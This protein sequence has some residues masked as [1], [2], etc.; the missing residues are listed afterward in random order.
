MIQPPDGNGPVN[1]AERRVVH[2]LVATLPENYIVIPNIEISEP[3]RQRFEYD[4][5]VVSPHAV[6]VLEVKDW[7]GKIVG[8]NVGWLVNGRSR[9]APIGATERKAKVLKSK[10]VA[11][12]PALVRVRVEAAVVL[13]SEPSSIDLTPEAAERTFSLD[14][15]LAFMM[16]PEA[17][18]QNPNCIA[19]LRLVI[20]EAIAGVGKRRQPVLRFG[21]YEVVETL[22]QDEDEAVYRARHKDM[23][24]APEVRLRVVT[25]S[26][27]LLT[28][29]QRAARKQQLF[30]EMEALLRMG[31]HPNVIAARTVF[32][33]DSGRVVVVLDSTEGR[34]LRQRLNNGTPL[35]V[36]QRIGIL[37]GV[38]RALAHAHSHGVIHRRVT[39]E[40]ILIDELGTVRL[41]QFGFSKLLVPQA[42]TVWDADA[43]SS[44][45]RRYLAPELN[46][47]ALGAPN[48]GTDLYGLGCIAF[49]LFAGTPPFEGPEQAFIGPPSVPVEMPQLL[50]EVLPSLLRAD[51]TVRA[52]DTKGALATLESLQGSGRSRPATG[53]KNDYEPGDLIDGKFEVR[54]RLGEGGFS[55]VYRVYL[56]MEDRE[57]ALKIFNA[58]D[59]YDKVQR[60]I[61][62]LRSINHEHIVKVV[63][64]D[65]TQAKQWYIVT[66][67]V[68]GQ[69]LSEYTE[70]AKRLAPQEALTIILDLLGALEAIQ[71]DEQRIAELRAKSELSADEFEELQHL[72]SGGIVHRDIKPQ[73]LI[74]SEDPEQG[75]VLIDFNIASKVGDPVVTVSGTPRY[76]APDANYT[77]WTVST[78]LFATAVVLYELLCAEHPYEDGQPRVDRVPIDARQF[79][80][81]FSPELCAFLTRACSPLAEQ[82]FS[83]A[84]E[85]RAALAAI[86]SL[87]VITRKATRG[88]LTPE[89]ARL[90][91]NVPRNV[92]PFVRE[93]L[94]LGSQARISNRSTRGLTDIARATYVPTRLDDELAISLLSGHHTLVV[95]TGN[96]GDGKTAFIQQVE[97]LAKEKGAIVEHST[98][99]G[100]HL[101]FANHRI[102]TLYDGS[103]DEEQRT[104]DDV[105]KEFFAPFAV[106]ANIDHGTVRIGAINEGRL[107]DF[108][109]AFRQDFPV[110]LDLLTQLDS[111]GSSEQDERIVLVNLNLRSLTGGGDQSIFTRQLRSIVD[112][113]FWEP[114]QACDYRTRCPIKHN[115]DTFR[116]PTS[117]ALV[118]ER[119]RRLIDLVRLRRRRHLTMR[120]LRSIISFILFRDRTC[121]EI[122]EVLRV[123]EPMEIADLAYFQGIGGLGVASGSVRDRVA[124]LLAE[125]DVAL[126]ANPNEDRSLAQ[127]R[128]PRRMNF[129]SRE[130]DYP[131]ELLMEA[132]RRAGYGYEGNPPTARRV[133]EALRR[134]V[135]FERSDDRWWDMLPYRKLKEFEK[136]LDAS[137]AGTR[138]QLRDEI[139]SALSSAEGIG[140]PKRGEALWIATNDE[141]E[142]GV[143]SYRRFAAADFMLGIVELSATY[144]EWQP[145]QL[146]LLH[147]PSGVALPIGVEL[148]GDPRAIARR[149]CALA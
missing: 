88:V 27:Y 132:Q 133:H 121:E 49:E 52:Q 93:F 26:R 84:R 85:M 34:T 59:A 86:D 31:S 91:E 42:A 102:V 137:A 24:A 48:P 119:L 118:A 50:A 72:Q 97:C 99:N 28:E 3:G 56:A 38:C 45:D 92:N 76:Q 4:V 6:Y 139:I 116:D 148:A 53:P 111:P 82:R 73:N 65:Q 60:E 77:N 8:D 20:A 33:D 22:E 78:D 63:W 39:P 30:R 95:I 138:S 67:L 120:D 127:G 71:P 134:L 146:Q 130:S 89:L 15:V 140:D 114:C 113:P 144:V 107:R 79:N 142:S 44:L 7:W 46:D 129:P 19:E 104:S 41:G 145:D 25:L 98:D 87:I 51:P 143:R 69:P 124:D 126:V 10:L 43:P 103:Q 5:I 110:V 1:D 112:G 80:G 117:G 37:V 40:S 11:A 122:G 64:A 14:K 81:G 83:S 100:T 17:I 125:A 9:K 55:N 29:A 2:T 90:L 47:P 58:S 35:T 57:F 13:A 135:F 61:Q 66:E 70:G 21:D 68:K 75:I 101:Q 23:P 128:S 36:E 149:P 106:N 54:E 147:T 109:Q 105:L 131:M 94:T 141:I 96:A 32:E 62:I 123:N 18:R 16:H 12:R 108:A 74:L 115:V 136:A